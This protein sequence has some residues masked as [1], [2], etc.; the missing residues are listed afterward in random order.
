MRLVAALGA[1][2][3]IV[4][5]HPLLPELERAGIRC[6][7][8]LVREPGSAA[9]DADRDGVVSFYG[10]RIAAPAWSIEAEG[11]AGGRAGSAMLAFERLF[12]AERPDATLVVGDS[13]VALA[14]AVTSAR[15]GIPVVHLDAGLRCGDLSVA[16][17]MHRVV[18]S[19]VAAMHLTPTVR[20]LENLEDE[21]IAPERIYFVGSLLAEAVSRMLERLEGEDVL[22]AADTPQAPYV[23]VSVHRAENLGDPARVGS[24][25][26]GLARAG[27]QALAVNGADLAEAVERH[28]MAMPDNVRVIGAVPYPVMVA[29]ERDALAVVTD[30]GSVQVEASTVGTPCL[31]FAETT[32]Q[33]TT[34]EIGANEL[35]AASPRALASALRSV[36]RSRRRWAVPQRWDRAVSDRVVRA[37][38]RGIMPL[39]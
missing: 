24:L 4:R 20:A 38:R 7:V 34:I 28:G 12:A 23:L 14:A 13:A 33:A 21:G 10:V 11:V 39:T 36:A 32:E 15:F 26:K 27:H 9:G 16:E 29:L 37:L 35:V 19:R 25:L 2:P 5:I 18:I 6:D 31:T 30:S 3:N 8:A 22:D 1:R 17:E